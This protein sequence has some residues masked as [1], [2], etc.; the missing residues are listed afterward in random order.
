MRGEGRV[1]SKKILMCFWVA[2]FI[3]YYLNSKTHAA[4]FGK[5]AIISGELDPGKKCVDG[6]AMGW[7]SVGSTLLFQVKMPTNGTFEF[8]MLPGK[9]NWVVTTSTGCFSETQVDV[10]E[11]DHKKI[12]SALTNSGQRKPA[13][14]KSG[15]SL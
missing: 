15:A 9:Y 7:L 2:L 1:M 8:Y 5:P 6:E 10:G 12:I 4:D 14:G 13:S 3:F 11:G